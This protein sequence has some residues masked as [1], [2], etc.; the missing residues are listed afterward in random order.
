MSDQMHT[1]TL[2]QDDVRRTH[3]A[4]TALRHSDVPIFDVAYHVPTFDSWSTG[5]LPPPIEYTRGDSMV[6]ARCD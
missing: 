6:V 2:A 5:F 4:A 3:E 1:A